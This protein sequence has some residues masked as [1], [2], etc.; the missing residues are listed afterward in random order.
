M[1]KETVF[2][3]KEFSKSYGK[4]LAVDSININVQKGEI[5]G[6]VGKNGAGKSTTLRCM[7]N[8]LF[9]SSGEILFGGLDSVKDIVKIK[10]FVGYMPSEAKYP[11]KLKGLELV[12]WA[13]PFAKMNIEEVLSLANYFELDL[14]KKVNEYSLGNRKKLSI[15]LLLMRKASIL[16]LDEPTN[17]LD[18]LMQ[19]KFFDKIAEAK[20]NGTT[21]FL[22]SH[23]LMEVQRYCDRV[24]IIKGG[25]I[26]D[27]LEGEAMT[28]LEQKW[29]FYE[30]PEGESVSFP[31]TGNLQELLLE[32]SKKELKNL[33]IRPKTVEEN[34]M[35]Y[36]EEDADV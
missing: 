3:I 12:Q 29:V 8:Y 9:P 21:V 36:Y 19:K 35:N 20:E 7:M 30:T 28:Q 32:L 31:I 25:K 2:E 6:F 33:E 11:G 23:N 16:L 4:F 24:V 18:P 27:V 15:V 14:S 1:K 13:I 22:S 34:F 5:V 26:V 10:E 17:G